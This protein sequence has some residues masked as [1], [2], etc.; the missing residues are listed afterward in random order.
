MVKKTSYS[1]FANKG[2]IVGI[3]K[4]TRADGMKPGSPGVVESTELEL[5][6][7]ARDCVVVLPFSYRSGMQAL[8]ETV[9]P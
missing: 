6:A 4:S 1:H 2:I 8:V 3:E 5:R 7:D 9:H